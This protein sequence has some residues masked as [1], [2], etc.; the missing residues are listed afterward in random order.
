MFSL[1]SRGETHFLFLYDVKKI[2]AETLKKAGLLLISDQLNDTVHIKWTLL[3]FNL[4]KIRMSIY[5]KKY[6]YCIQ[7]ILAFSKNLVNES[8]QNCALILHSSH[9][10]NGINV[11]LHYN[12]KKC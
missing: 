8:Y 6:G 3:N 2:R 7:K 1:N 5:I 10:D 11:K 12:R 9:S 4:F